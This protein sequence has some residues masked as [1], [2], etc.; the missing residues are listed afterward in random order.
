M[1]YQMATDETAAQEYQIA[2]EYDRDYYNVENMQKAFDYYI[3][4]AKKGYA[5]AQYTVGVYYNIGD[6]DL[7][8]SIDYSKS[9][10]YLLLA[11][12]QGHRMAMYLIGIAYKYGEGVGLNT[13]IAFQ[14]F[15]LSAVHGYDLAIYELATF[16]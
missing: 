11:A 1:S 6:D 5:E 13:T 9:L 10:Y 2:Q 8:I 14:W 4:S 12:R 16:Q 15:H 7:D 3:L